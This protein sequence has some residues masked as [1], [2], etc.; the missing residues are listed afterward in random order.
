[1]PTLEAGSKF[2]NITKSV[3]AYVRTHLVTGLGYTVY[4]AGQDRVGSLPARWVE[5]DLIPGSG[6]A[7][8]MAASDEGLSTWVEC[9]LNFNCYEQME[10]GIGTSNLYSLITMVERIRERFLVG[11]AI[12]IKNYDT[13]GAPWAGSLMV[14]ERPDITEVPIAPDS[15]IKQINISVPLRYHEVITIA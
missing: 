10:T 8:V 15:G 7:G 2:S 14:W 12:D 11:S 13:A 6:L 4:Y 9:F 3:N 1:M 5:A